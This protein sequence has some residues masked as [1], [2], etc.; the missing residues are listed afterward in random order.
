MRSDKLVIFFIFLVL[1][2]LVFKYYNKLDPKPIN[3]LVNR[4]NLLISFKSNEFSLT[5][6]LKTH[7]PNHD[8]LELP[9]T[10]NFA[11]HKLGFFQTNKREVNWYSERG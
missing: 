2:N 8:K 10:L 7:P 3:M 5:Q 11:S 9:L 4:L 1:T 6:S